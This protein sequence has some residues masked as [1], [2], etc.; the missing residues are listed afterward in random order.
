[1]QGVA[2]V[3]PL[4]LGAGLKVLYDVLLYVN[5]RKLKPP[6]ERESVL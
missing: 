2:L 4:L 5:F 3:T 6:E 1:M